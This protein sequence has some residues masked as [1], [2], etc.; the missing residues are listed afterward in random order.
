MSDETVLVE[1][2][3]VGITVISST[4]LIFGT[5]LLAA[6]FTRVGDGDPGKLLK[7]LAFERL[8]LIPASFP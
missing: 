4:N 3:Y 1:P 7:N 2:R 6:V 5:V 8:D